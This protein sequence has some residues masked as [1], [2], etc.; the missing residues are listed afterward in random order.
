MIK[1]AQFKNPIEDKDE[2]G[3][4]GEGSSSDDV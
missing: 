4:G 3:G 2:V 1:S